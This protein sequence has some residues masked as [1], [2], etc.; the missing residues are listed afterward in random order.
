MYYFITSDQAVNNYYILKY[1]TQTQSHTH[2]HTD[3]LTQV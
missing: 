1:Y 2:A 3:P